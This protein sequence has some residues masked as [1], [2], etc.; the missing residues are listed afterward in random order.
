MTAIL[1]TQKDFTQNACC[2]FT[3]D[4]VETK[5]KFDRIETIKY[6]SYFKEEKIISNKT[7]NFTRSNENQLVF[8]QAMKIR[9]IMT[10]MKDEKYY[11]DTRGTSYR[12]RKKS[13]QLRYT[14][15]YGFRL[16]ID[17][18]DFK[19]RLSHFMIGA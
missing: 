3:S 17:S 12:K 15:I 5:V 13:L 1:I 18:F 8:S 14:I 4:W 2:C 7:S 9:R 16:K 6:I 10:R 11:P 19:Y